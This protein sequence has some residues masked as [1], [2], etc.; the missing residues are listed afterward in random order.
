V[1]RKV[2]VVA[3]RMS[4]TVTKRGFDGGDERLP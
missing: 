3:I 4:R 2:K 1:G